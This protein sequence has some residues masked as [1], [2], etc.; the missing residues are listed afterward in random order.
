MGSASAA[1]HTVQPDTEPAAGTGLAADIALVDIDLAAVGT[2]PEAVDTALA[3]TGPAAADIVAFAGIAVVVAGADI[4][5]A[6][7]D[8]DPERLQHPQPKMRPR[9]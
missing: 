7:A 4:A 9:R 8:T 1:D 6:A 2:A 5:A 3:D